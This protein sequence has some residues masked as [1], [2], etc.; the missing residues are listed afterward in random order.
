LLEQTSR[1]N[2]DGS[3]RRVFYSDLVSI[4]KLQDEVVKGLEDSS[5]YYPLTEDEVIMLLDKKG[6]SLGAFNNEGEL[7]GYAAAYFPGYSQDNLGL[8]LKFYESQLLQV[9]HIE[10]GFVSPSWRGQG[11]Q[12][13]LYQELIKGIISTGQYRYILSTVACNN[14]PALHNSL[15]LQLYIT[16]LL[17]KYRNWL[18]YLLIRDINEPIYINK[19]ANISC[20]PLEIDRQLE[21]LKQGYYGFAV[22][23]VDNSL[24]IYYGNRLGVR[25]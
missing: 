10:A 21:L 8:D 25:R 2:P 6:F 20:H 16:G 3:I 14:Y 7:I 22:K 1:S 18:R 13:M 11:W 17:Q 15:R 9:A 19:N 12:F 4:I 24:L 23:N 5:A